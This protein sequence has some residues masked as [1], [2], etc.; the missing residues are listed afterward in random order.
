MTETQKQLTVDRNTQNTQTHRNTMHTHVQ[1]KIV[2]NI[3]NIVNVI[4]IVNVCTQTIGC[5]IGKNC[6]P[7]QPWP[8]D[9]DPE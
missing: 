9:G 6:V 4:N 7:E 2:I 1:I 3:A 8:F 5:R